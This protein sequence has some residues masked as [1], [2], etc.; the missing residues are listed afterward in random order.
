A[1]EQLERLGIRDRVTLLDRYIPDDDVSLYFS[2]AD[3]VVQPYRSA[4]QSGVVQTAFQF[5]RPV[6]VTDVGAL[7][8]AVEHDVDGLIVP[9]G[10][11]SELAAA[12]ERYF[13]EQGLAERLTRGASGSEYRMTWTEF[14]ARLFD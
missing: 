10:N 11:P 8:S 5:G 6:V 7:G 1:D 2:A 12:I 13:D 14:T 3:V 4:T 9:P